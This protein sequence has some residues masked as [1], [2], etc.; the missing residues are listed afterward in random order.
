M[1]LSLV[2][3][4]AAFS[5]VLAEDLDWIKHINWFYR[6]KGRLY[7]GMKAATCISVLS[8]SMVLWDCFSKTSFAEGFVYLICILLMCIWVWLHLIKD[9]QWLWTVLLQNECFAS[10]LFFK[11]VTYQS[12]YSFCNNHLEW[13]F[14]S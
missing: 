14:W 7:S 5:A 9:D 10:F 1:S 4:N 12:L 2:C 6:V 3:V 11:D 8:F 13:N